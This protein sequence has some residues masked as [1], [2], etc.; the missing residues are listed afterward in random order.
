MAW[1]T[2]CLVAEKDGNQLVL[3]PFRPRPGREDRRRIIWTDY[4]YSAAGSYPATGMGQW[5]DWPHVLDEHPIRRLKVVAG[6]G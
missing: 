6:S 1:P 5:P 3:C 2:A 4:D